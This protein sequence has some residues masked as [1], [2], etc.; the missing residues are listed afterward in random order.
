MKAYRDRYSDFTDSGAQ[1]LAISV[2]S[3][4]AQ[5]R[6][7][8]KLGAPFPFI[9]DHDARLAERYGV[10]GL[11]FGLAKRTTFVVGTDGRVVRVA[12]GVK[13]FRPTAVLSACRIG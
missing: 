5:A 8:Q 9:A 1:V 10:K 7:K 6:F 2:D 13:A 12:K 4:K 11:L 3:Q